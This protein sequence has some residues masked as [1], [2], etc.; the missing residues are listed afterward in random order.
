MRSSWSWPHAVWPLRLE[1]ADHG[2]GHLLDADRSGRRDRRRRTGSAPAVWPEQRDLGRAVHVLRARAAGRSTTRP[3]AR[4]EVVGG[5]ALDDR[6]PVEVAEDR[7]GPCRAP[8]GA[9]TCDGGHLA[10]D[11]PRV[12]LGQRLLAARAHAHAA[13]G[14]RAGDTTMRFEPMALDLL[15]DARLGAGAHGDHGDHRGHADDDAEHGERAAQL[16]HAER[17]R[18]RSAPLPRAFMPPPPRRAV[19]SAS[20]GGASPGSAT[21]VVGAA[22]GRRGTRRSR[23]RTRRCRARG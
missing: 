6:G 11:R 10:R 5:D 18:A 4:L 19:G 12:V 14:L 20:L 3:V 23:A 9:A 2:E 13:R 21:G 15:G 22:G 16:V 8:T 17:A 7:P 1:H